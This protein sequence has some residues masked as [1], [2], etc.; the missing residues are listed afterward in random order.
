LLVPENIDLNTVLYKRARNKECA[1]MI[2]WKDIADCCP[3]SVIFYPPSSCVRCQRN[4]IW[5]YY[6]IIRLVQVAIMNMIAVNNL[7]KY[8]FTQICSKVLRRTTA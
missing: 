6:E 4:G 2:R 1:T 5:N 3:A 7:L 8:F